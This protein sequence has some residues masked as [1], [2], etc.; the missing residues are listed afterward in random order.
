MT[1]DLNSRQVKFAN[2]VASGKT[3]VGAYRLVYE[4][5]DPRA[6]HVYRNSR[7][8]AAHPQVRA[9]IRE[10]QELLFTEDAGEIQRHALAVVHRLS[11]SASSERVRLGA[12][13]L[14]FALSEK[15][16]A[17]RD[18]VPQQQGWAMV[19]LGRIYRQLTTLADKQDPV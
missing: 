14:L 4:P 13:E 11:L 17:A 1:R 10:L 9:K 12:A 19:E 8:L 15:L 2:L 3:L 16:Q 18:A 6:A 7:R 5:G